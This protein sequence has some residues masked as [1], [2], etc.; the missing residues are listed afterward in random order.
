M[1]Y[2]VRD[3][4]IGEEVKTFRLVS[5]DHVGYEM[6]TMCKDEYKDFHRGVEGNFIGHTIRGIH[7][8]QIEEPIKEIIGEWWG[9]QGHCISVK[10]EEV[11]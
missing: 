8:D 9:S 5:A 1:K 11:K 3:C 7:P 10:F 4:A 6:G 2:C